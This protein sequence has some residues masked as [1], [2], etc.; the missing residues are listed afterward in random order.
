MDDSVTKSLLAGLSGKELEDV[1]S[2]FVS[3]RYQAGDTIIQMGDE[4]DELFLIITGK[5]RVW[6]GDE[7]N[8]CL[9]YTSPSPRDS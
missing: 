8:S 2:A 5:V 7:P 9:L 6:T 3:R 1:L 4:D